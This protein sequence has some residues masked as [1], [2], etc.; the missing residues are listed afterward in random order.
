VNKHLNEVSS[1]G[2]STTTDSEPDFGNFLA[3]GKIRKLSSEL[4]GKS[5][6]WF[7]NGGYIQTQFPQADDIWGG[8]FDELTAFNLDPGIYRVSAQEKLKVPPEWKRQ[9]GIDN[10][11]SLTKANSVTHGGD[12]YTDET[13]DDIDVDLPNYKDFF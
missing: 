12:E 6:A 10:V 4:R 13:F 8:K 9:V 7:A 3:G 5:D 11:N 1:A 2:I